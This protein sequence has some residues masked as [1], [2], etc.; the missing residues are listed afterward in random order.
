MARTNWLKPYFVKHRLACSLHYSV[1]RLE[2]NISTVDVAL[3]D[4]RVI[5]RIGLRVYSLIDEDAS[6][7]V[8]L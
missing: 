8:Q 7:V 3:H 6:N 1:H 2:I 4:L 5:A